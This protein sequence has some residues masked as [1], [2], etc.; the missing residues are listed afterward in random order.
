MRK[1][2]IVALEIDEMLAEDLLI[3]EIEKMESE[4]N[5]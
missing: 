4:N 5:G 3:R 2:D 1:E